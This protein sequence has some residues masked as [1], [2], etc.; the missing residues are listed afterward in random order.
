MIKYSENNQKG[1]FSKKDS[2]VPPEKIR[3]QFEDKFS[4]TLTGEEIL[5]LKDN[6]EI[7]SI[8]IV[9]K[10]FPL[11]LDS[12]PQINANKTWKV[13]LDNI[14]LTGIKETICILDT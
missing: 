5:M 13:Q 1:L 3:H 6:P 8:E 4:A 14:N 2:I 7:E 11:L 12:I 10:K 9:G